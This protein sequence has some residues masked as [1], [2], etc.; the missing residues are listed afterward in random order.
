GAT[1]PSAAPGGA[2]RVITQPP[3]EPI[4]SRHRPARSTGGGC[5]GGGGRR[6]RGGGGFGLGAGGAGKRGAGGVSRPRPGGGGREE[7]VWAARARGGLPGDMVMQKGAETSDGN[8]SKRQW[9]EWR[10]SVAARR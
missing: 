8:G 1:E 2:V 9:G 7:G 3:P 10:R 4:D 6:R 5:G